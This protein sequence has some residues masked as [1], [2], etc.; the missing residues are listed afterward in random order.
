MSGPLLNPLGKIEC[1]CAVCNKCWKIQGFPVCAYGGPYGGYIDDAGH[2][3][4]RDNIH[5]WRER[6]NK[7]GGS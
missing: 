1:R 4:T 3:Y 5:E 2:T 7:D 6:K